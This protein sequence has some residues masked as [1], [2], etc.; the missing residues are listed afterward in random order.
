[1]V[2]CCSYDMCGACDVLRT[3]VHG[4]GEVWSVWERGAVYRR[5]SEFRGEV[6]SVGG[7]VRGPGAGLLFRRQVSSSG[8]RFPVPAARLQL[9]GRVS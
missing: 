4:V 1:M 5:R 9:R 2:G 3:A 6:S 8:A 7:R